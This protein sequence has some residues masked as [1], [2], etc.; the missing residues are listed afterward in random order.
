MSKF[1]W[2]ELETLSNEI[3][4]TQSRLDAARATQHL[5]L[6]QIL[7]RELA[8]ALNKRGQV[9]ADITN[10]LGFTGSNSKLVTKPA[11]QPGRAPVDEPDTSPARQPDRAQVKQAPSAIKVQP[12]PISATA[13]DDPALSPNTE[14]ED[15]SMWDT[16]TRADIERVNRGLNTRRAEILARHAEELKALEADQNEIEVFEKAIAAFSEKFHLT[17]TAELLVLNKERISA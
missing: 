9:L 4:H 17:K 13:P 15:Y 5:G 10:G 3:A 1:E 6:V 12:Q 11:S 14:K 8:D 7:E 16:L 2:M